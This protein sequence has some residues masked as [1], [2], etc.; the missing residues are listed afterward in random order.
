MC[1]KIAVH[2]GKALTPE[3]L[4]KTMKSVVSSFRS[5]DFKLSDLEHGLKDDWC[6][7][8]GLP[9][10]RGVLHIL[11]P[12]KETL[13]TQITKLAKNPEPLFNINVTSQFS[14]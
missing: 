10:Y 12:Q 1:Q 2:L 4:T 5:K 6:R 13:R 3:N 9:L 8:H 7:E 11:A 14:N